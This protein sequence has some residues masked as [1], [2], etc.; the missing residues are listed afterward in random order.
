[1]S[2]S[3]YVTSKE[4]CQSGEL[5]KALLAC[6]R[7]ISDNPEDVA[8]RLELARVYCLLGY[9]SFAEA[10]ITLL[11]DLLPNNQFI[12]R[13]QSLISQRGSGSKSHESISKVSGVEE[14]VVGEEIFADVEIDIEQ[15]K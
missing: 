2:S 4:L 11:L 3:F 7:W 6:V 8:A 1:L 9:F 5:E 15:I 10:E 14:E 12:Q 13:L